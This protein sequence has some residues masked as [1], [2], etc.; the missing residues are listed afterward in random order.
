MT[1]IKHVIF[2]YSGIT[3][4]YEPSDLLYRTF[5]SF[6]STFTNAI[7]VSSFLSSSFNFASSNVIGFIS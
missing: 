6:V 4:P 7:K 1:R 3:I 2:G 5:T